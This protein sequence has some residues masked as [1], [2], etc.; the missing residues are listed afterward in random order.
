MSM[1]EDMEKQT[2][3]WAMILHL[4]QL[5]S[6]IVPLAG[7][8]APIVIWQI[9]KTEL[10][11]IDVHGKIVVNWI[12]S[13]VIYAVV[14][15]LLIVVVIGF[16]LLIVVAIVGIVFPIIGGIKA[17]NGEVWKYPLTISFIK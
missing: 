12:I 17:S 16:P 10:P 5:A 2:R 15:V 7:L 6:L 1:P 8:I 14:S 11:G 4:S 9:K 13:A 3:T